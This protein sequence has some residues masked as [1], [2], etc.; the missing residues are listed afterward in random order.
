M[1]WGF[2]RV[3]ECGYISIADN[4]R[5]LNRRKRD[6]HARNRDHNKRFDQLEALLQISF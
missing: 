2:G 1:G 6:T 4:G 5:E 3:W